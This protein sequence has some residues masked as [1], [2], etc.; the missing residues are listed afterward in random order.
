MTTLGGISAVEG[1]GS[2]EQ[3]NTQTQEE[4]HKS[5]K[6][7]TK[8]QQNKNKHTVAIRNKSISEEHK[9]GRHQSKPSKCTETQRANR[10]RRSGQWSLR[11][12]FQESC[13]MDR[14]MT[15]PSY[16]D[17]MNEVD[18]KNCFAVAPEGQEE[19]TQK[20]EELKAF[21]GRQAIRNMTEARQWK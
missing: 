20:P 8:G 19:A 5:G 9:K 11:A 3:G 13:D 2:R 21:K 16:E 18:K 14:L 10:Q 6:G 7:A 12:G 4:S 15:E 1:V 17:L